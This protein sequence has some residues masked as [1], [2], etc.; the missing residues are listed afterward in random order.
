M[1]VQPSAIM[2]AIE[3]SRLSG[4]YNEVCTSITRFFNNADALHAAFWAKVGS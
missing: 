2:A 4:E 3:A 1:P